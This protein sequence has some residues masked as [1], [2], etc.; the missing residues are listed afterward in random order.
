LCHGVPVGD[1]I[2]LRVA[3]AFP[4]LRH[5]LRSILAVEDRYLLAQLAEI[6]ARLADASRLLVDQ[7]ANTGVNDHCVTGPH[8]A[9]TKT[10]GSSGAGMA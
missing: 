2:S 8:I 5:V 6:N 10:T 1:I 4:L 3:G 9:W 7:G